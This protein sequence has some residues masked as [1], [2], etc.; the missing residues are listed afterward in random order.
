MKTTIK[1]Q[2]KSIFF[3]EL[4][5]NFAESCR[6]ITEL[7]KVYMAFAD[8]KISLDEFSELRRMILEEQSG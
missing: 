2:D 7:W 5:K 8:G 3:T 6:K 4:A 1:G